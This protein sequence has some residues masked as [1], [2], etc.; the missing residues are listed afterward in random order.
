M[1]I[2]KQSGTS[3]PSARHIAIVSL[4]VFAAF[5]ILTYLGNFSPVWLSLAALGMLLLPV[6][7][8]WRRRAWVD[9]G[10]SLRN[11]ASALW[12]GLGGGFLSTLVGLLVIGKIEIPDD[13][14]A[15]LAVAIPMWLLMASPFQEFFFRG[16]LQSRLASALGMWPGLLLTLTCFTL[17][18]FTLPIFGP[19]S[20]FP[21]FT[22][23]GVV[24]TIASGFIY[25]YVFQRTQNIIAPWLAHAMSGIAFVIIG[26]ATFIPPAP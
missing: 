17:W 26:A 12:W 3:G 8:A 9:M 1:T 14:L 11:L 10:F 24:G 21:M 25:G 2:T 6:I 22:V 23:R 7:W 16:W 13:L 5:S 19:Q 4:S 15:Q 20:T 18:H